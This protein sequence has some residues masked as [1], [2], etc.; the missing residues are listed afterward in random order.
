MDLSGTTLAVHFQ[1]NNCTPCNCLVV[2]NFNLMSEL[3]EKFVQI[4]LLQTSL[5]N[6]HCIVKLHLFIVV[7]NNVR[8]LG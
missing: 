8:N 7:I 2:C 3:L 1:K 6:K 5:E 4:L